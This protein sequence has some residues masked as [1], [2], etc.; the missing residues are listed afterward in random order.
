MDCRIKSGNDSTLGFAKRSTHPAICCPAGKSLGQ[1][2]G[3]RVQPL[4]KKYSDFPK[5][6]I[7]LYP[8]PSRPTEGRLAI[9]TAAG[10]GA[11]DADA[12]ITNGAEADGEVVWS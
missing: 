6:Q 3:P 7:T 9:V 12:P 2:I 4:S 5:T 10:R 1:F 11:V 8:P